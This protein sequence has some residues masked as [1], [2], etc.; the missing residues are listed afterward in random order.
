MAPETAARETVVRDNGAG[1]GHW[2]TELSWDFGRLKID[3]P[4]AYGSPPLEDPGTQL[5]G[6]AQNS[7][8]HDV[9]RG[10][11]NREG[12]NEHVPAAG[13]SGI[14]GGSLLLGAVGDPMEAA[15][16]RAA[17]EKNG[18]APAARGAA[19]FEGTAPGIVP[20]ALASGGRPL[21]EPIRRT[22]ER[23]FGHDF[24]TVR[25][26]AGSEEARAARAVGADAF[27]V[28]EHIVLGDMGAPEALLAHELTH[29]LQQ[30]TAQSLWVQRQSGGQTPARADYV[31]IMG[32]DKRGDPNRFYEAATVY[33]QGRLPQATMVT[34]QR[35]LKDLLDWIAANVKSP[36]GNLY[37][38]SHGAED[39]TLFFGLNSPGGKLT[40]NALRD[41]LHPQGGGA[42]SQLASVA[43]VVD[44]RTRIHIKGCNIGQTQEMVELIDEAFGA[45][46][47]VTAPT[48]EQDYE[49]DRA[50]G[51]QARKAEHDKDIAQFTATLP[52]LPQAP[53]PV[54][55]KLKGEAKKTAQQ[56]HDAAAA[57]RKKAEDDRKKA[58]AQEEKRIL[59]EL[60]ATQKREGVAESISGP[61]FQRPGTQL[62]T[63]AELQP[64][65][66][67]LY[68]HLSKERRAEMVKKLVARDRGT[69]ANPQ[70]QKVD[71]I[72]GRWFNFPDPATV[73]EAKAAFARQFRAQAFE[74]KSMQATPGTSPTGGAATDYTFTGTAHPRGQPSSDVTIPWNVPLPNEA[75]LLAQSKLQVNNPGNYTW[76]VQR[77]HTASTGMTKVQV[78][79]ERVIAYL[80]HGSLDA[81]PHQHFTEPESNPDFYATS[82]V[83]TPQQRVISSLH[84]E[85]RRVGAT[86]ESLK[87]ESAGAKY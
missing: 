1:A 79:G 65:V 61:L 73:A 29:V 15:A 41:A 87:M 42:S 45:A 26:H 70:G 55:R 48:H 2:P 28:G 50:L 21:D 86:I 14:G 76:R 71:R 10:A 77:T 84:E 72:M 30:R 37:I 38:V 66:D 3:A 54:D 27:T 40:V 17:L 52:A 12:R 69:P 59:P 56:A 20:R 23:R 31:F 53:A 4:G 11:A 34:N 51:K 32:S 16:E 58:I 82:T 36:I 19:R 43:S 62:Y 85:V 57:A 78:I 63:A 22:F 44:G 25:V 75:D 5:R 7:S 60:E 46:G 24:S 39:G 80:H 67:R 9:L 13:R 64:E 33:F 6:D 35:S 83:M 74:L 18:E 68:G 49:T 8:E 47:T 81:G